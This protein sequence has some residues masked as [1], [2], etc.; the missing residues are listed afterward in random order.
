MSSDYGLGDIPDSLL[1][2]TSY[3]FCCAINLEKN[4]LIL[5]VVQLIWRKIQDYVNFKSL[6]GVSSSQMYIS[7]KNYPCKG[8]CQKLWLQIWIEG[9]WMSGENL[10]LT[11]P[12][13]T[14][15][16]FLEQSM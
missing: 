5:S 10:L 7:F 3:S 1:K 15:L 12:Q 6:V 16:S 4:P 9:A 14:S 8:L 11:K 13:K 2:F